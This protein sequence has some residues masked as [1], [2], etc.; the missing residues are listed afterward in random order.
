[1]TRFIIQ[2]LLQA[3]LTVLIV[4]I[5]VF[6]FVQLSGDPAALLVPEQASVEDIARMRERLGLDRPL[7]I[8]YLYF[9]RDFWRGEGV[10][11]FRYH[12]PL[13]PLIL[14]ALRWTLVLAGGTLLV[15]VLIAIPLGTLAGIRRGSIVDVLIRIVAV[16]GQSMPSFWVAMLVVLFF[17]VELR[18][19]P[20]SGLGVKNAVLPIATLSF[21]QVA[22]LLR[23]FRSEILEVLSKDYIRTAR[24]KGL[25]ETTVLSRHVFKNAFLPVL[26]M[27]GLQL[28]G[29]VMGAVVVE[30]IFA[31]PGLGSL[32]VNSVFARD[33]PVVVGGS[34]V[35]AVVVALVNLLVDILYG[36]LDP[37]IRIS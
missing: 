7:H 19:F 35:A 9:M 14:D 31:W 2:R 33:Y 10:Q 21:F 28:S 23:L 5:V 15:S 24:A 25:P 1:M 34:I 4:S 6:L 3:V 29:L 11:S 8:Q 18:L 30:P 20:V 12:Q 17:A 27:A 37:R 26:T 16:F 13:L 22:V 36:V 32:M